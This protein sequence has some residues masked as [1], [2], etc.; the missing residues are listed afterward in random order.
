[1]AEVNLMVLPPTLRRALLRDPAAM[2]AFTALA[3]TERRAVTE[4]SL[5]S[6][7][8]AQLREYAAAVTGTRL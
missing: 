2:A 6:V 7:S 1:M 8:A 5:R 3:P 4:G